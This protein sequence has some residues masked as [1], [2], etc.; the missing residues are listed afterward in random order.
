M[1]IEAQCCPSRGETGGDPMATQFCGRTRREFF[2][3]LGAGF[4]GVALTGLLEQDAFFARAD[5]PAAGLLAPRAP[6]FPPR[7]KACIFLYMYGGP[8]QMDLFDY[9]PEL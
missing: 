7:A 2:W 4:A 5:A 9:K 6:H 8:S 1:W 3:E